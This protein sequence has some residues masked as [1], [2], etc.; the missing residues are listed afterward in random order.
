MAEVPGQLWLFDLE[1][2][3]GQKNNLADGNPTSKPLPGPLKRIV[4]SQQLMGR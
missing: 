3:A 4:L 1:S 2:E